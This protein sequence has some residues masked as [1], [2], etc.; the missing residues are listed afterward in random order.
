MSN[1]LCTAAEAS[2]LGVT[3]SQ[4]LLDAASVVIEKRTRKI[5][6]Q[7]EVS[8]RLDGWRKRINLQWRPI[9]SVESIE[10]PAGNT[11]LATDFFIDKDHGWVE[12]FGYFPI[13]MTE[14]GQKALWEVS[15]T[16]GRFATTADV[17]SD[18]KEACTRLAKWWAD[19]P[20]GNVTSVQAGSLSVSYGAMLSGSILPGDVENLL[21]PYI[22]P[23]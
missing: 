9:V 19:Q 15:Y 17:T 8:E 3:V 4:A 2:A 22:G 7:R 12:H 20:A 1:T 18:L 10:D 16:A 5:F 14:Q 13:P 23:W 6:V 11:V 21:A